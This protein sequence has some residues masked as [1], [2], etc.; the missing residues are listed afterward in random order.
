MILNY[1]TID[2]YK[3]WPL[4]CQS[5]AFLQ[6]DLPLYSINISWG[7]KQRETKKL[8]KNYAKIS[9]TATEQMKSARGG[10][11]RKEI[12]MYW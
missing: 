6:K 4:L 3:M 10:T 9:Q 1:S 2:R 7:Q 5:V 8:S 12:N 11:E